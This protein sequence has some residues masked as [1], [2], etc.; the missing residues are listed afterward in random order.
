M[1]KVHVPNPGGIGYEA[2]RFTQPDQ[3]A[4]RSSPD[5]HLVDAMDEGRHEGGLL[6]EQPTIA[7]CLMP[8]FG[9]ISTHHRRVCSPGAVLL[10]V[11]ALTFPFCGCSRTK[12]RRAADQEAAC[13][14]AEKGG[15]AQDRVIYA[16]PYSRLA[17]PASVDCPPIPPDDPHSHELMHNVDGKSGFDGWHRFGDVPQVESSLWQQ[18]LIRDGEGEIVVDLR[19][20]G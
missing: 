17:D 14:I 2:D 10:A 13:L 19:E 5:D 16:D 4:K 3:A 9:S 12:Y 15:D 6:S 8:T 11:A 20:R 18:S 7:R 1:D